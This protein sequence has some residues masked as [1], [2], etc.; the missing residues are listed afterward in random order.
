MK[1]GAAPHVICLIRYAYWSTETE[2][3]DT[4]WSVNEIWLT[5]LIDSS[6]KLWIYVF[7]AFFIIISFSLTAANN[8]LRGVQI[9]D[10]NNSSRFSF[11]INDVKILSTKYYILILSD[12]YKKSRIYSLLHFWD[13][14]FNINICS[15]NV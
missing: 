11:E 1:I 8:I 5:R 12:K 10:N 3:K 2:R 7:A 6:D 9:I 4:A 13:N 14:I 15:V